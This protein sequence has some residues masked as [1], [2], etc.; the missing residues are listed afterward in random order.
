MDQY[1]TIAAPAR[2]NKSRESFSEA[3]LAFPPENASN[4]SKDSIPVPVKH[5]PTRSQRVSRERVSQGDATRAL[6]WFAF[7]VAVGASALWIVNRSSWTRSPAAH[8]TSPFESPRT[9]PERTVAVVVAPALRPET[10]PALTAAASPSARSR[11]SLPSASSSPS[12]PPSLST[13]PSSS[14]RL[15]P[16]HTIDRTTRVETLPAAPSERARASLLQPSSVPGLRPAE[17][18]STLPSAT[19]HNDAHDVAQSG[20]PAPLTGFR[21]SLAIDSSP[22]G[23][24]VFV[25]GWPVG[26]T[27]LLLNDVPA[28]SCVVR[29]E[30]DGYQTWSSAVRVVADEQSR[31]TVTLDGTLNP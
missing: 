18:G 24:K 7:G 28:G 11:S 6:I 25:N 12:A 2:M 19:V 8:Q 17:T 27:P 20:A 23:A 14:V 29:I 22:A 9:S 31:I 15:P 16:A 3:L 26:S 13:R 1:Q 30:A 5:F 10:T 4:Q 21:G